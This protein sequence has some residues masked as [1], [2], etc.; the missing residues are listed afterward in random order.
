MAVITWCGSRNFGNGTLAALAV[1]VPEPLTIV[2]LLCFGGVVAAQ[3]LI[4][5]QRGKSRKV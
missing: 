3:I 1:S 5:R 4:N 2:M